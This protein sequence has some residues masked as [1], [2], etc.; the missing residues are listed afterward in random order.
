MQVRQMANHDSSRLSRAM[1]RVNVSHIFNSSRLVYFLLLFRIL[2]QLK[3]NKCTFTL[4]IFP[5][6]EC[7][8]ICSTNIFSPNKITAI[9]TK[10]IF[11]IHVHFYDWGS[12]CCESNAI[13]PVTDN[14]SYAIT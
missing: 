11:L 3:L 14:D 10:N 12:F 1:P 4:R 13:F 6:L 9:R 7:P 2:F 8:V 5:Y